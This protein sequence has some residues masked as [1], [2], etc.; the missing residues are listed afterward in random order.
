MAQVLGGRLLA[1]EGEHCAFVAVEHEG[2]ETVLE[3]FSEDGVERADQHE[4]G[5]FWES[6]RSQLQLAH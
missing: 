3:L 2:L 5:A 1:D 6:A 4:H